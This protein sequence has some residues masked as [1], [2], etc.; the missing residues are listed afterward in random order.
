MV[1]PSGQGTTTSASVVA[2]P[3]KVVV[4]TN[5]PTNPCSGYSV[6]TPSVTIWYQT[7]FNPFTQKIQI[8]PLCALLPCIPAPAGAPSTGGT[9]VGPTAGSANQAAGQAQQP[10]QDITKDP[11]PPQATATPD[12]LTIQWDASSGCCPPE[13]IDVEIHVN[14]RGR[15]GIYTTASS[16][17]RSGNSFKVPLKEF[18]DSLMKQILLTDCYDLCAPINLDGPAEVFVYPRC[19]AGSK[20]PNNP[21]GPPVWKL[22][23]PSVA[24]PTMNSLQ[25]TVQAKP[26]SGRL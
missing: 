11:D 4:L 7:Y 15:K 3:P 1:A 24:V 18:G 8:V 25:I 16:I 14:Y 17:Q 5:Q 9:V 19:W 10:R 6:T 26:F 2:A 23:E 21:T 12:P 13:Y 20:D 22:E